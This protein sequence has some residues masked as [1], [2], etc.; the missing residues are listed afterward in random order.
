MKPH[1]LHVLNLCQTPILEQ[2]QL[3]EAL[4][5]ADDRNWCLINYGSPPAIVMGISSKIDDLIHLDRWRAQPI[6]IIRRFSGGGTVVIDEKCVFVTFICSS[7]FAK[8][9]PYPHSIMRWT[10][11]FYRSLFE[12]GSFALKDNDYVLGDRKFGGN[13]QS[14]TKNRWLHH[15]SL[16]WDYDEG[17]MSL[18]K[19]PAKAPAYRERRDHGDFL[20]RLKAYWA[21][22]EAMKEAIML[23]LHSKFD[24][25]V[26]SVGEI[27]GIL[28]LPHRKASRLEAIE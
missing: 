1:V 11:P 28:D 25:H 13:A 18:L 21:S 8:V 6:P 4:L 17:R 23:Q 22:P 20:C 10:E 26:T 27:R 14:I 3:E 5:R 19:N 9:S 2:L 24:I 12:E 15:S 16:L 7:S